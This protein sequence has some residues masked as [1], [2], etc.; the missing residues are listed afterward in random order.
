MPLTTEQLEWVKN[1]YGFGEN[2][3]EHRY[4]ILLPIK[5]FPDWFAAKP[6]REQVEDDY[7]GDLDYGDAEFDFDKVDDEHLQITHP[8]PDFWTSGDV[9]LEALEEAILKKLYLK[10][11]WVEMT[12]DG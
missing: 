7:E 5:H 11:E 2:D 6:S 4:H 9:D 3:S 8:V 10:P 12:C 1:P